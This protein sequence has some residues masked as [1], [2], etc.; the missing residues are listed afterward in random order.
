MPDSERKSTDAEALRQGFSLGEWHVQPLL[1]RISSARQDIVL[2]PQAM[3]L[4]C[5][6]AERAGQV[7]A[8]DEIVRIVWAGRPISDNPVYKTINKLR[9][10]LGD[11]SRRPSYIATVTKRGYRLIAPVI[12]E[13]PGSIG[14]QAAEPAVVEPSAAAGAAASQRSADSV[15]AGATRRHLWIL[16]CALLVLA[17]AVAAL[18]RRNQPTLQPRVTQVLAMPGSSTD[19][20]IAADGS[21]AFINDSSGADELWWLPGGT[22]V[23]QQLT[24]SAGTVS[25]P[26]W[27]PDGQWLVFGQDGDIWRLRPGQ[28]PRRLI[29]NARNASYSADG[30]RLVFERDA[31]VWLARADGAGQRR[32]PGIAEREQY[33]QP[34]RPVFSPD[35]RLLAYFEAT[36]GPTGDI[37]TVDLQTAVRTRRTFDQTTAGHPVFSPDG[38]WLYF[39]S[40]RTGTLTLWRLSLAGGEPE[41]LLASAGDD[42]LPAIARD[43]RSLIYTADRSQWSLVVSD[44]ADGRTFVQYDSRYEIYAPELSPDGS[45]L[46]FFETD[47]F[48]GASLIVQDFASR[49]LE[50]LPTEPG[51]LNVMPKWSADGDWIY[52]YQVAEQSSWRRVSV[53]GGA[54]ELLL[55]DWRFNVEHDVTLRPRSREVIYARLQGDEVLSTRLKNLDSGEEQPFPAKISWP[56]WSADGRELLATEFSA[57]PLP[58]GRMVLC[59]ETPALRWDCS[60]LAERGQHPVWGHEPDEI[61]YVLPTGDR[62]MDLWLIQRSSGEPRRLMELSPAATSVSPFFDVTADGRVVWVRHQASSSELWRLNW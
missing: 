44:P 48:R 60:T 62:A 52:Y 57:S 41:S 8:T 30:T 22:T 35:G 47:Q 40:S 25:D 29:R 49:A 1:N 5:L 7:V 32:F 28:E 26:A 14:P 20:A 12:L 16:L 53:E 39:H 56:D 58:I 23:P 50:R 54:S 37:W 42:T 17:A 45:R 31:A 24:F 13:D 6:L 18:Q 10:A 43:G 15:R 46:V 38:Q 27:S 4:L 33:F 55:E 2:E 21:I 11:P 59:S 19:G 61:Y 34:R 51:T 36:E 3:E 9:R